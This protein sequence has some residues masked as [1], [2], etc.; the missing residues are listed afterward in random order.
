MALETTHRYDDIIMMPHHRSYTRPHMPARDRAA[1]FMP[2]AALA[3]YDE[4][5]ERTARRVE[6]A[7]AADAPDN[8]VSDNGAS[9]PYASGT[10]ASDHVASGDDASDGVALG[11][12]A[13]GDFVFD[14]VVPEGD[15][16]KGRV[17]ERDELEG[18]GTE[19]A[20]PKDVAPE[21][22]L[23]EDPGRVSGRCDASH[24]GQPRAADAG[25]ATLEG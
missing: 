20:A 19:D 2:F 14:D 11:K 6:R 13:P 25:A 12:V 10:V 21:R 7:Y 16:P 23:S 4:I 24:R 9:D 18:S 22:C 5:I 3:G 1:Q 15:G 17:P 8:V